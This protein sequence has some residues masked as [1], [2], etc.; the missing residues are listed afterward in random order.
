[1]TCLVNC[2]TQILERLQVVS[3]VDGIPS[4]PKRKMQKGGRTGLCVHA[5]SCSFAVVSSQAAGFE[6]WSLCSPGNENS[7]YSSKVKHR[8][9]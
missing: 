2:H 3:A 5:S 9:K 8:S 4:A 1:L 7:I 6:G